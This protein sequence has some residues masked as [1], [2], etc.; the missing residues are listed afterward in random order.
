[1]KFSEARDIEGH[2]STVRP[3]FGVQDEFNP[4]AEVGIFSR[5]GDV[6][7]SRTCII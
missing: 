7:K 4:V 6:Y 2:F 1:M 3:N 5:C